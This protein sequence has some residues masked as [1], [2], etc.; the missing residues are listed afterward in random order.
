MLTQLLLAALAYL[1][2]SVLFSYHLPLWFKGVNVVEG[3]GDR[4][5]GTVN[6]FRFAGAPLGMA[7]LALD[8]AKAAFPVW[9]GI[10]LFGPGFP[11]LPLVMFA[12]VAGHA[13]TPWYRFP[14]GKAIAAAFGALTGLLPFSGAVYLLAFWYLFFSLVWVIRPNERRSVYT[15]VAFSLCAVFGAFFTRRFSLALG[16]VLVA[17]MPVYKNYL[18]IGRARQAAME[19]KPPELIQPE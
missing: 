1:L 3:S 11:L 13:T 17:V 16:C 10:R 14:G 6:A 4:N 7:C 15:F 5:P 12:P 9:L 2:G 19:H 8:M 18:D